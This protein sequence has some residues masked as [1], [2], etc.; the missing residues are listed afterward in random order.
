MEQKRLNC[1]E[2]SIKATKAMRQSV[3]LIRNAGG[4]PFNKKSF[5]FYKT[6]LSSY[7]IFSGN[8][9]LITLS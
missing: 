2:K 5:I 7:V 9:I 1:L 3:A 6:C 4:N 8:I